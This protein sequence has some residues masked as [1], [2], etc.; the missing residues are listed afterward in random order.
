MRLPTATELIEADL[1]SSHSFLRAREPS[2]HD[3]EGAFIYDVHHPEHGRVGLLS[4]AVGVGGPGAPKGQDVKTAKIGVKVKSKHR[5]DIGLMNKV[6]RE[7][8]RKHP[9]ITHVGG[10]RL[11]GTRDHKG[12]SA[13]DSYTWVPLSEQYRSISLIEASLSEGIITH[14]SRIDRISSILDANAFKSDRVSF[15]KY[16]QYS[17]YG[18]GTFLA[19][20]K[21]SLEAHNN[22][23]FE[24][25]VYYDVAPSGVYKRGGKKF[26]TRSDSEGPSR[27]LDIGGKLR[28]TTKVTSGSG[29]DH[30]LFWKIR[31]SGRADEPFEYKP[32]REVAAV[33][34]VKFK[35][36][37][38][39]YLGYHAVLSP[40]TSDT[41][42][43]ERPEHIFIKHENEIKK[44]KELAAKHNLP[45]RLSVQLDSN[46][47]KYDDFMATGRSKP[48][49]NFLTHVRDKGHSD[50]ASKAV[51]ALGTMHDT[52]KLSKSTHPS[53]RSNMT[54]EEII[55]SKLNADSLGGF[56]PEGRHTVGE[57]NFDSVDGEGNTPNHKNINY[58]GFVHHMKPSEFLSLS[59]HRGDHESQEGLTSHI[60]SG[61]SIA[62]PQ[63]YV[64]YNSETGNFKVTNHEGRGRSKAVHSIQPDKDIPVHIIPTYN[65][66]EMRSR[67]V[68]PSHLK[69]RLSPQSGATN[70]SYRFTPRVSTHDGETVKNR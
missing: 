30:D 14:S 59:S 19:F 7:L 18:H 49:D 40:Y 6:R 17:H 63:L 42:D 41:H 34:G 47:P 60:K 38:I 39:R 56:D 29:Y 33:K 9:D 5:G 15:S 70:P 48:I 32:E 10:F 27:F 4:L 43:P 50:L 46:H 8:A 1:N 13:K 52:P 58:L 68:N 11:T 37:H 3:R 57:V 21:K 2:R 45:V 51:V 53:L 26:S 20:D 36:E 28:R 54:A 66:M 12:S 24:R 64:D 25:P 55:E 61:G 22:S 16:P 65:G 69:S 67:H 35:R 31:D 23:S 44:V 62:S